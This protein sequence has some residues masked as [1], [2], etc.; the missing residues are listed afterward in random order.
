MIF[1]W[2]KPRFEFLPDDTT[3][4]ILKNA[5][6]GDYINANYVNM[7][8]NGTDTTNQYIATQGPLQSTSEDFWQMVLEEDCNLIVMLTTIVERGRAKCHKYWPNQGECLTMQNVI[9]KC[10]QEITDPSE[11][12]IFRDF[13][14]TDV[15]VRRRVYKTRQTFKFCDFRTTPN[16]K[17]NT[18]ST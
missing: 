14:L 17:S 13:I 10:V 7:K 2:L 8:I 6:S 16:V 9:I 5:P 4:V 15:K 12:F 11:S 18:C 1:Q 3:R